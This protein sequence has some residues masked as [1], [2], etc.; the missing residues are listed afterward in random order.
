MKFPYAGQPEGEPADPNQR[1]RSR[2]FE[3]REIRMPCI[4]E[5]QD[6]TAALEREMDKPDITFGWMSM[7]KTMLWCLWE[8]RQLDEFVKQHTAGVFAGDPIARG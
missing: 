3:G 4:R 5:L 2:N 7:L 1:P 8:I 6:L